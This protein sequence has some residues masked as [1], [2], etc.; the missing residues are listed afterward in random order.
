MRRVERRVEIQAKE[1]QCLHFSNASHSSFSLDEYFTMHIA[2]VKQFHLCMHWKNK[3]KKSITLLDF[4]IFFP[5]EQVLKVSIHWVSTKLHC[6]VFV[7][8]SELLMCP[9]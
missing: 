1:L 8:C 5:Y 9:K 7:T 3:L 6:S 4:L 2:L